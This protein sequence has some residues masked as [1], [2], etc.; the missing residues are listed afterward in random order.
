MGC[1]GLDPV[2]SLPWLEDEQAVGGGTGSPASPFLLHPAMTEQKGEA[3]VRGVGVG[4]GFQRMGSK[5]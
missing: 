3:A 4:S 1:L 2:P 5:A